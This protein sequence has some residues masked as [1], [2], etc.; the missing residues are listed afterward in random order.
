MG[1][2]IHVIYSLAVTATIWLAGYLVRR[3]ITQLAQEAGIDNPFQTDAGLEVSPGL[4]RAIAITDALHHW[5]FSLLG[6]VFGISFISI[7][8]FTDGSI[9]TSI[10]S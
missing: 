6:G 2:F 4:L 3:R 1:L 5:R 9:S 7:Q 10:S 8:I